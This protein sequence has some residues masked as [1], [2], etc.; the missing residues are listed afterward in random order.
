MP[1]PDFSFAEP[2][3]VSTSMSP[4]P[5]VTTVSLKVPV[6]RMSADPVWMFE[7]L[8]CGQVTA[9]STDGLW[10][11]S[12]P[13][14]RGKSTTHLA[15][16]LLDPGLGDGLLAGGV[17]RCQLHGGAVG[18]LGVDGDVAGRGADHDGGRPGVSKVCMVSLLF[19]VRSR[20]A[21]SSDPAPDVLAATA[22]AGD[23]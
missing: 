6:A 11:N 14:W 12:P 21:G 13:R 1:D 10:R 7:E 3:T 20:R 22:V 4:D 9:T 16:V 17:E 2:V 15:A 5:V 19:G 8:P 18:V 23:A